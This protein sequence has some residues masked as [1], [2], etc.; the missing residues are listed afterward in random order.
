MISEKYGLETLSAE[1]DKKL[2]E[3]LSLPSV[4]LSEL[5][6]S[7][8]AIQK[9][10]PAS[11]SEHSYFEIQQVVSSIE[12]AV[13]ILNAYVRVS[14]WKIIHFKTERSSQDEIDLKIEKETLSL[15]KI[16]FELNCLDPD[17]AK[18]QKE[19]VEEKEK[20]KQFVKEKDTAKLAYDEYCKEIPAKVVD[21]IQGFVN[22][23]FHFKFK[24]VPMET[25]RQTNEYPFDFEIVDE[26]G[27]RRD[28]DDGLSEGERQV[29]SLCF[30]FATLPESELKNKIV[31]FDDPI[32]SLDS[33][34]L[35][36]LV[37]LIKSKCK[38]AQT[39]VLTHHPLFYKYLSKDL[40]GAIF[41]V[42]RNKKS[43]GGSFIYREN[44]KL[45]ILD[46]LEAIPDE[47]KR[48]LDVGEMDAQA[49]TLEHGH[50][51]RYAVEKFVKD[52]LQGWSETRFENRIRRLREKPEK[53]VDFDAILAIYNFCDWSNHLHPDKE[54]PSALNEL[55]LHV[56]KF[57]EIAKPHRELWASDNNSDKH[58]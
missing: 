16:E 3:I 14:R 22:D 36:R 49:F 4:N 2:N 25:N 39:F 56:E 42:L 10:E 54:D 45:T 33:R 37:D 20:L 48:R 32:T 15:Q 44:K 57:V 12:K 41:G 18:R 40:G 51:L 21:R 55:L 52:G 31:V 26:V 11:F 1:T 7:L 28:F 30:F 35:K 47:M 58:R 38:E 9:D 24:L 29:I 8:E 19:I 46:R 53:E 6:K 50:L 13:R 34:N 5:K 43:F 23:H 17:W 27:K